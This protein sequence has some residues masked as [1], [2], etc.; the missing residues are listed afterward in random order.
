MSCC[1]RVPGK[2]ARVASALSILLTAVAQAASP[3][4]SP[5]IIEPTDI[6]DL[7]EV[8]DS[9][10]SPD[11]KSIVYSVLRRLSGAEH[12]DT[13]IWLVPADGSKAERPLVFGA[14]AS[15]NVR[16]SPDGKSI[17]FLSSRANPL[18]SGSSV[19]LEFKAEGASADASAGKDDSSRQLWLLSLD[20]GEAQPLTRIEGD[21]TDFRW[22]P[23]GS[24]IAFLAAD[25]LPPDVRARVG[26]RQDAIEVDANPQMQRVWIYDLRARSA[27]RSPRPPKAIG[28]ERTFRMCSTASTR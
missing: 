24:R 12:D 6:V 26:L 21:I 27:Q 22:S 18:K 19:P 11:G 25:P 28:A 14:G 2:T 3:S 1:K 23:D 20:G 16:W 10:I 13:S 9:Q 7:R 5:K 17:A 8:S 4:A 15:G